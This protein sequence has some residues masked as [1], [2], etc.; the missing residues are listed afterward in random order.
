MFCNFEFVK[1]KVCQMWGLIIFDSKVRILCWPH[2]DLLSEPRPPD[3]GTAETW[4]SWQMFSST[5][6]CRHCHLHLPPEESW[7]SYSQFELVEMWGSNFNVPLLAQ[8]SNAV[9]ID[10][11][12]YN[13]LS[14][15]FKTVSAVSA[16]GKCRGFSKVELQMH[17][18]YL[19]ECWV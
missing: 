2:H 8:S 18:Q 14:S 16:V 5:C 12:N 15:R 13:S 11:N 17:F 1:T 7:K 9:L 6:L 4:G 19:Y 3:S 10:N